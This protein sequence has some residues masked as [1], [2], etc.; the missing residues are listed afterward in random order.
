[1]LTSTLLLLGAS[2]GSVVSSPLRRRQ[3]PS[4][5]PVVTDATYDGQCYYPKPDEDDFELDEYVGRWYQVAGTV[6]PFTAGCKCIFAEYSLN[7]GVYAGIV[8]QVLTL[9]C[10]GKWHGACIQ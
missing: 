1:M 7:V 8:V 5:T 10:A 4:Q 9:L 3:A 2:L 6:A